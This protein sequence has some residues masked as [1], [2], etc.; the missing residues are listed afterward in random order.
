MFGGEPGTIAGIQRFL[1]AEHR[2]VG[3]VP[4]DGG[5]LEVL[6]PGM[7]KGT[8]LRILADALG[9]DWDDVYAAGDGY[10]DVDMLKIAAA[11]FV[12]ENGDGP[13]R[14]CATYLVCSN[15]DGAIADAVGIL[16]T[17]YAGR[18]R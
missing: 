15:V 6:K 10:N 16:R 4:T 2:E 7:N 1:A 3:F 12:P 5:Y 18:A 11:A 8:S 14:A 17:I 13:A 9:L